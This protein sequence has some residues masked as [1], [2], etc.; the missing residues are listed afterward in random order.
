MKTLLISTDFSDNATNAAVY[1]YKLA[2]QIKADV[3]LCNS[4]IVPA[5][6][7]QSG[8]IVWP[9]EEYDT[10]VNNST[11]ELK[12]LKE[13]LESD[14]DQGD[15]KPGVTYVNQPGLVT[16]VINGIAAKQDVG[17]VVMGTHGHNGLSQL[18]LGNHARN[19]IDTTTRP[20][21]LL[22]PQAQFG[23]IK[24][25]A[26]AVDFADPDK[27]LEAV[28][29]LIPFARHLN[30]EILLTHIYNEKHHPADFKDRVEKFMVE[31]SNKANFPHIY[32]RVIKN[33][34]VEDG[35]DF[36]C[37]HGHI[38]MLAMV[39]RPHNFFDKLLKGSHTQKIAGRINIPL[40][41]FPA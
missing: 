12:N 39:H 6:I 22:P 27:D 26:F 38:D 37:W 41:V 32:Y 31:I 11:D 18:I 10:L 28:Y 30:A 4:V 9:L 25:I 5:E 19:M 7:P 33:Y 15:F 14:G 16:D 29:K 24:K 35:L 40:L 2:K 20:L 8:T 1:G 13:R 34:Q 17:M 36:I 21:L 23:P 3:T